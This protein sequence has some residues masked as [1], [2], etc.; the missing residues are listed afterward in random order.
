M[1]GIGQNSVCQLISCSLCVGNQEPGK[2]WQNHYKQ[3][4][5]SGFYSRTYPKSSMEKCLIDHEWY[6]GAKETGNT[7]K[8]SIALIWRWRNKGNACLTL[9][10]K[11]LIKRSW[12]SEYIWWA[13]T[14]PLWGCPGHVLWTVLGE[15]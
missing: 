15:A 10:N 7:T 9:G 2:G 14:G 11:P 8:G 4:N 13:Y 12:S 5:K 3:R 6:E 1:T